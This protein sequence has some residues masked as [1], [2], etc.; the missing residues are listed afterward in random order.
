M[1]TKH[2]DARLLMLSIAAALGAAPLALHAAPAVALT[3]FE[4]LGTDSGPGTDVMT[5]F[6]PTG[7]D[8]FHANSDVDGNSRFFHTYGFTSGLTYFGARV[9]G[10]G[11]FFGQTSATHTD[12]FVNTSGAPQLA[13]FAFNVDFGQIA[14]SGTGTGYSDLL[15]SLQFGSTTVAREH[16]R[17]VYDSGGTSSCTVDDLDAGVL[18]GYLSCSGTTA[19]TGN[20]CSYSV[21]Q[22]VADGETLSVTYSI[23]AEVAGQMDES[24]SEVFC[25]GGDQGPDVP[26]AAAV[27]D[28]GIPGD[29]PGESGCRFFNGISHSGDPAGFTPVPFNPG[30]FSLS[31]SPLSVPEPGSLALAALALGGLAGARRRRS[32][33]GGR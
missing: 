21:S 17:I 6:P 16:G 29:L 10:T 5:A 22:V 19:A 11:T 9:S 24:T 31:S 25:S 27:G 4:A 18:A 14:L 32:P 13:T 12:T 23:V 30:S 28:I 3:A 33:A 26:S 1:G 8:F 20:P 2:V 7:G 15:L